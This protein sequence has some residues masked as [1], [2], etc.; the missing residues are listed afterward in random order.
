[1]NPFARRIGVWCPNQNILPKLA[2]SIANSIPESAI[3]KICINKNYAQ[4][5][6]NDG[7]II[8]FLK[9][10]ENNRGN[11][12]HE[13]YI[14]DYEAFDEDFIW[15]VIV[16]TS[17]LDPAQIFVVTTYNIDPFYFHYV[18]LLKYIVNKKENPALKVKPTPLPIKEI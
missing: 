11:R 2:R 13:N 12:L 18:D 16:P 4:I 9:Q 1:M 6:L 7:S 5:S 10:C 15:K 8:Y 3:L 14:F 17:T